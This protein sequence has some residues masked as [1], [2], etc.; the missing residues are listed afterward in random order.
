MTNKQRF[1]P[2][3]LRVGLVLPA[4]GQLI[5]LVGILETF[6]AA[7]RIAAAR[8]KPRLFETTMLGLEA[9]TRT[10]S[11]AVMSTEPVAHVTAVDMVVVGGGLNAT[12]TDA[13]PLQPAL[14]DAVERLA[15]TARYVAS[16]C[17]GAFAL[18]ELGLLSDTRCTTHWLVSGELQ[19][20][21]PTA[22]VQSDALYT[23]DK[24]VLT[25]AG[26]AAATDLA[27]HLVRKF[28]GPRLALSVARA[29]VVF[30]QRPGGQSQFGST[31]R[32]R[33]SADDRIRAVVASIVADPAASHRVDDLAARC[34]M[35]SRN[36]ARIFRAETEQSP[37]AFVVQVRVEAA[38]R[39][40]AHGDSGLLEVAEQ[41]GFASLE[42]F[43]RA[44]VRTA[45]VTP[46][47]YRLRFGRHPPVDPSGSRPKA[48]R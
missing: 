1:P 38:Q 14:L 40:L 26:A 5:G 43:R 24:R 4:G 42:T 35:S 2:A 21:F 29:L 7:N 19:R 10:A 28:A 8:G 48:S 16:S 22:L 45:G 11:G 9:Q 41:V 18:G 17:T 44:F 46:S 34:A 12:G 6:D 47:A 31:L 37:A 30:A 23:E 20:R 25:A 36:F 33:A 13:L 27:L 39:L 3:A 15:S 32:L